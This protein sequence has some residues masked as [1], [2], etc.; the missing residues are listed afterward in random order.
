MLTF[1]FPLYFMIGREVGCFSKSSSC[2]LGFEV[3]RFNQALVDFWIHK[4]LGQGSSR[5]ASV[6]QINGLVWQEAILMAV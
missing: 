6:Q 3:F 5:P 1:E 4:S 2:R